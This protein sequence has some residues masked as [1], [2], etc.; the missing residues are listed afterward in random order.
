MMMS[1]KAEALIEAKRLGIDSSRIV[2]SNK[3]EWVGRNGRPAL[4]K[5]S[6][7]RVGKVTVFLEAIYAVEETVLDVFKEVRDWDESEHP[8][9]EDGKFTFGGGGGGDSD[10]GSA[11]V[12]FVSPNVASHLNFSQAVS[13]INGD[14][15]KA[16]KDASEFID[17]ELGIVATHHDIIGAWADGAEN[18][19]ASIVP[20][21]KWDNLR[22]GAAMKG[23]LAD[24]KSVLVF[25][26]GAGDAV[27]YSFEAGDL[28]DIHKSLIQDGIGFHTLVPNKGGATVLVADLDGSM[29]GAVEKGSGRYDATVEVRTGQAEFIGTT[30]EDGTDRE[31]RDSARAGY[32]SV[33]AES[34][35]QGSQG[36]WQRVRD[37]WGA[38][39]VDSDSKSPAADLLAK[40][41][42]D[43][44]TIDDVKSRLSP[45]FKAEAKK[46]EEEMN[47]MEITSI[48]YTGPDGKY[49]QGRASAHS[50]ILR[51][52][53]TPEKIAAAVPKAGEKPVLTLSGGR[54]AAGKT[55]SLEKELS[56]KLKTSFYLS[57]DDIQV[58]L[59]GYKGRHAGIYN[60]EAQDI[61]LQAEKV[62][63]HMG[64]NIIYD[65]TLKSKQPAL[66]RVL[67]YKAAGYDVDGY[68]VHTTPATSA[69]RSADRFMS[70]KNGLGRYLPPEASFNNRTSESTFDSLIPHLRNWALYDNNGAK[71]VRIAG[72]K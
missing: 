44:I 52:M 15:Q 71:P 20:T 19:V 49:V 29:A 6:I 54:P 37:R 42:D 36:V 16:L 59:P 31:Q 32:E 28:A 35:V 39:E 60:S 7:D 14:Q 66:D 18:S 26:Q 1:V 8:R 11:G 53:F 70:D 46:A 58:K 48:K 38:T 62:A 64:L 57:A 65:A 2:F 61:A 33:I 17:K 34:T 68:F 40:H 41:H 25:Q 4:C 9:D 10:S 67:N 69:L 72:S 55:T 23:Y 22:V 12:E 47:G 43:D 30:K 50:A 51:Q 27:L 3:L 45:E 13:A 5:A 24:Q 56:E 63:R 21:S